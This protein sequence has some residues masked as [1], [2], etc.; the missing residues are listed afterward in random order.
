MFVHK[1][2]NSWLL[3][4]LGKCTKN[5]QNYLLG[6]LVVLTA[7]ADDASV[8]AGLTAVPAEVGL[9]TE[10]DLVAPIRSAEGAAVDGLA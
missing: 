6:P 2:A 9:A 1:P 8:L 5:F 4:P 7:L 3:L 10:V